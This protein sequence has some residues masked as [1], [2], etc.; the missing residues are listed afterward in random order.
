MF[1]VL[2]DVL[3]HQILLFQVAQVWQWGGI[4]PSGPAIFIESHVFV[5]PAV[6]ED[7]ACG[8]VHQ[9]HLFFFGE[10]FVAQF[11]QLPNTNQE[12]DGI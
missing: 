5:I 4:F 10:G 9:M 7:F 12:Q 11:P 1:K 8:D 3:A 2:Y 6:T